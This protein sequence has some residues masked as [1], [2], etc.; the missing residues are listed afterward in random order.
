MRL[1]ELLDVVNPDRERVMV[2]LG[3]V[4]SDARN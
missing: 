2:V 1:G 4:S 3:G